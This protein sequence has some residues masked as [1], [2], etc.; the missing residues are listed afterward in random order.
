MWSRHI[1]FVE[2]HPKRYA[3]ITPVYLL[4]IPV[5]DWTDIGVW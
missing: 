4:L 2:E 1:P 3:T 5:I